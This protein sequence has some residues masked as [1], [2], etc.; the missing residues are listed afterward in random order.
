MTSDGDPNAATSS[1]LCAIFD[2]D[3]TLIDY[4]GASHIALR[5]G[6]GDAVEAGAFTWELHGSIIGTRPE[7]WSRNILAALRISPETLTS[8]QYVDRYHDLMEDLYKT[9]GPMP[10]AITLVEELQR[11]GVRLAIATSSIRDSFDKKMAYH[12]RLL[13]PMEVIVTGDD[14]AVKRGKPS[15]DI[16]LEAARRLGVNPKDCVVFEDAPSGIAAAREAGMH[17]VAIPDSRFSATD[18]SRAHQVLASLNDWTAKLD[19]LSELPKC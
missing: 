19:P 3:G 14:P 6:L 5:D 10:G 16:F 12:P 18:F 7:S 13:S 15:P 1:F 4:E 11:R 17:A 2:L 9:I 8:E